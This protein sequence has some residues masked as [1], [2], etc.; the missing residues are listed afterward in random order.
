[1]H[2]IVPPLAAPQ[3]HFFTTRTTNM[4]KYSLPLTHAN[5]LRYLLNHAK[6]IFMF[7]QKYFNCTRIVDR[8]STSVIMER[9]VTSLAPGRRP[10]ALRR[11]RIQCTATLAASRALTTA[12]SIT[13]GPPKSYRDIAPALPDCRS[14]RVIASPL[15]HLNIKHTV[16]GTGCQ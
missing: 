16:V 6:I 9:R 8:Q 12:A 2:C 14:D 1:L 4:Y 3:V 5:Q 10:S 13:K 15:S 11:R 7:N